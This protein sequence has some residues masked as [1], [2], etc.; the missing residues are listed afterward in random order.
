MRKQI[1]KKFFLFNLMIGIVSIANVFSQT[2]TTKLVKYTPAFK[3]TEGLYLNFDMFKTN[4]PILKS[5]IVTNISLKDIDFFDKIM[6]NKTIS[7][8]DDYGIKQ[9]YR[10]DR[11]WGYSRKGTIFI[12]VEGEFNRIPVLG[13]ISHFVANITVYKDRMYNPYDPY[14]SY[15]YSSSFRQQQATYELRQF[16]LDF[17]TGKIME[18]DYQT[19]SIILMRDPE[20]YEEFNALKKRKKKQLKFLYLRKYNEKHPLYI[21]VYY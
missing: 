19:L 10:T 5:R 16:I 17:D 15:S 3:F 1:I 6:L 14:Y 12:Q 2:D 13:S 18:Y 7:Y 8:Y 11:I 20:L 9:E 4:N 21:P